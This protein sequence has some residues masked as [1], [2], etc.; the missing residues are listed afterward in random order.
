MCHSGYSV[1]LDASGR[2]GR[3]DRPRQL[4]GQNRCG[5]RHRETGGR[6]HDRQ[7]KAGDS[8]QWEEHGIGNA[9]RAQSAVGAR[10]RCAEHDRG[11]DEQEGSPQARS[12]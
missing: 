9:D 12:R 3:L 1:T 11:S 5:D 4:N 6:L 2:S 7:Q 10:D 8:E